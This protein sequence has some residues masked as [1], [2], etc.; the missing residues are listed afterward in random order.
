MFRSAICFAGSASFTW[1]WACLVRLRTEKVNNFSQRHIISN[2]RALLQLFSI[3]ITRPIV[4]VS[5]E[6]TTQIA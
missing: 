3:I 5:C 4:P 1:R 6:A 2:T